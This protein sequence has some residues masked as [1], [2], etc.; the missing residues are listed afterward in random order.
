MEEFSVDVSEVE[1]KANNKKNLIIIGSII[2]A[3]VV[4]AAIIVCVMFFLGSDKK[5]LAKAMLNLVED[6]GSYAETVISTK[7]LM[8][9]AQRTLYGDCGVEY[10]V[11]VS[12]LE[13]VPATI[14][15]DGEL[16]RRFDDKK[17]YSTNNLS[18]MNIDIASLNA[19]ADDT[20]LYAQVPQLFDNVFMADG[21]SIGKDLNDSVLASLVG[22]ALPE[23]FEIRPFGDGVK[24]NIESVDVSQILPKY[25]SDC[26]ALYKAMDVSHE[27]GK[28]QIKLDN[29]EQI[30]CV[31]YK[32]ILP[33]DETNTLLRYLLTDNELGIS[34]KLSLIEE[35]SANIDI[36][37]DM[38][39][40]SD[41]DNYLLE[42]DVNASVWV[43][44]DGYVR[45]ITTDEKV[46]MKG[47][48]FDLSADYIGAEVETDDIVM[49]FSG[50]DGAYT[51]D[52]ES[53][54]LRDTRGDF[55]TETS[56]SGDFDVTTK[57]GGKLNY[58][59]I[60]EELDI[61]IDEFEV[62]ENGK[63]LFHVSGECKFMDASAKKVELP[64]EKLTDIMHMS[65]IDMLDLAAQLQQNAGFLKQ[66][67]DMSGGIFG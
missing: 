56:I 65:L 62:S 48:S 22:V 28:V 58:D 49:A 27:K 36:N 57:I 30:E 16:V 55:E 10:S 37:M 18:V 60:N 45:K 50:T 40:V 15:V 32:V 33:V 5:K 3:V 1:V 66:L 9:I 17:M 67:Y 35:K 12:G 59:S 42:T 26:L 52:V 34:K 54:L 7:Q 64:T 2:G 24:K 53:S 19:Y 63:K 47:V 4:V 51:L 38:S 21:A 25:T 23:D 41:I 46:V 6:N 14:G 13:N 39:G 11:N 44:T 29:G 20:M 8:D 43:D 61:D 31:V